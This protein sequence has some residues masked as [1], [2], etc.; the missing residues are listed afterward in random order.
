[1]IDVYVSTVL[2]HGAQGQSRIGTCYEI[3]ARVSMCAPI[4]LYVIGTKS[5]AGPRTW[6]CAVYI[7][8]DETVVVTSCKLIS[9][10]MQ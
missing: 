4:N 8:D 3:Y 5:P 9:C 7:P 6:T 2:W 1:M 10:A